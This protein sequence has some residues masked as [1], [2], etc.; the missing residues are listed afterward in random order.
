MIE[1]IPLLSQMPS[2][3]IQG[4]FYTNRRDFQAL[5]IDYA[6]QKLPTEVMN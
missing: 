5:A 2:S 1:G 6:D 3:P 4:Q